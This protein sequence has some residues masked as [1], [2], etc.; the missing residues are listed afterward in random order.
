[1]VE[2]EVLILMMIED[3]LADNGCQTVC[4]ASTV[5]AAIG[6]LNER[7][8]DAAMI[9]L[10]LN[11]TLSYRVA[12]ELIAQRIPFFFCTGNSHTDLKE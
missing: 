2:D 11:G 5:I 8:F 10:N 6:L 12:D 4:S 1:M 7:H 9:D 3:V